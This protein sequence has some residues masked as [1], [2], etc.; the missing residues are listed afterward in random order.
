MTRLV[1]DNA[2][3]TTLAAYRYLMT[4]V[5]SADIFQSFSKANISNEEEMKR[6]GGKFKEVLL[7]PGFHVDGNRVLQDLC[8]RDSMSTEGFFSM[9]K[10]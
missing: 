8:G 6:L 5:I 1:E 7:K 3:G 4:E 10:L 9:Y 2:R